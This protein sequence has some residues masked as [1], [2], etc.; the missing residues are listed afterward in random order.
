MFWYSI[1]F[2]EN[3]H[4]KNDVVYLFQ[5][6]DKLAIQ[7]YKQMEMDAKEMVNNFTWQV[8]EKESTPNFTGTRR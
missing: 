2:S 4:L 5:P 3:F 6:P 8:Q 1:T 7:L